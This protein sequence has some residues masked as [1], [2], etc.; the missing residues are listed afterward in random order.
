MLYSLSVRTFPFLFFFRY[1][2]RYI[3]SVSLL[4]FVID[5]RFFF[6]SWIVP[7]LRLLTILYIISCCFV[8]YGTEMSIATGYQP[9]PRRHRHSRSGSA[10]M[11]ISG[12]GAW[13]AALA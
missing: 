5:M 7:I 8:M 1:V 6:L 12:T 2:I 3:P 13:Q 10:A 9:L 11:G 4:L